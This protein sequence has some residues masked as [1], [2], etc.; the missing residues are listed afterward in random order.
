MKC[1]TALFSLHKIE[2]VLYTKESENCELHFC[3]MTTSLN[4]VLYYPEG[5]TVSSLT[6]ENYWIVEFHGV[7]FALTIG[8]Y[9]GCCQL[10]YRAS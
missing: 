2:P 7:G 9:R 8:I 6:L 5:V 4:E 1:T 3:V 10:P